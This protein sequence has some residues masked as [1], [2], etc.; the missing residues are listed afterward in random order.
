MPL[1][2]EKTFSDDEFIAALSFILPPAKA[3]EMGLAF[4]SVPD[5]TGFDGATSEELAA[6]PVNG[7]R[8]YDGDILDLLAMVSDSCA[9]RAW[10]LLEITP[11]EGERRRAEFRRRLDDALRLRDAE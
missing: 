4:N 11:A 5:L 3:R 7:P 9:E 2:D 1:R 6:A 8:S 10:R